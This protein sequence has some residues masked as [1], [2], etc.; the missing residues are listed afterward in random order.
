MKIFFDRTLRFFNKGKGG[1]RGE[2]ITTSSGCHD[3]VKRGGS[4]IHP[5]NEEMRTRNNRLVKM[6]GREKKGRR[7]HRF[8]TALS[9]HLRGGK[10]NKKLNGRKWSW[11]LNLR[12]ISKKKKKEISFLRDCLIGKKGGTG[13]KGRKFS[14][15]LITSEEK[16]KKKKN[17]RCSYFPIDVGWENGKR[18]G[19]KGAHATKERREFCLITAVLSSLG[20]KGK[21]KTLRWTRMDVL[22]IR[23]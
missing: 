10:G 8:S 2:A 12:Q 5:P 7:G 18:G 19:M 13:E 23:N 17:P 21:K 4:E 20:K 15:C 3:G 16:R 11:S 1:R 14:P 6:G 22:R 9:T